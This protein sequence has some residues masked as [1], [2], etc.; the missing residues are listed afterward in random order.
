MKSDLGFGY[1][2]RQGAKNA[3]F[4]ILFP[5]LCGLCV[6]AGNIPRFGCT[7]AAPRSLALN[8]FYG[9]IDSGK[10]FDGAQTLTVKLLQPSTRN[11]RMMR[12]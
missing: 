3:K 6:F 1:C 4:G 11:S 10:Y 8:F 12:M 9:F 5:C 2:F 7:Y